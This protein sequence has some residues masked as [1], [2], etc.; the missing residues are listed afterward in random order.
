VSAIPVFH[1][2]ISQDGRVELAEQE[3]PMRT[4]YLR[5]LAG[6]EVEF[7]IRKAKKERSPRAHR[8]YFGVIVPM[9][10]EH[11]GYEKDEMHE[12][13]AFKFLRTEDDPITGSPRRKHLPETDSKE[14]TDY[15]DSCIR[16]GA[17]LG[18]VIPEPGEV[19]A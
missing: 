13:L 14:F 18:V 12:L 15:I 11:C 3:K 4:S 8:Y 6:Q 2:R 9:L 7:T 5:S 17:E 1:A 16:L 19:A 10:A